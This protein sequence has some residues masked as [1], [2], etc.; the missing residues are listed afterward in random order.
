VT[1]RTLQIPSTLPTLDELWGTDGMD[2]KSINDKYLDLL[3]PS[4]N[5]HTIHTEM[6][7][8]QHELRFRTLLLIV[9]WRARSLL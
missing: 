2:A 9:V 3:E 6:G 4:L 7:G 5:V 8:G 1:F